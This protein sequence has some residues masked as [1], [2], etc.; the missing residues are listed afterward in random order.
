MPYVQMGFRTVL[1]SSSLFSVVSSD[2]LPNIRD[3]SED[4]RITVT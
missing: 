4:G 2:F 1:Y 3:L